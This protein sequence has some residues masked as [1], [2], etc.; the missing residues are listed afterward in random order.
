MSPFILAPSGR[1]SHSICASAS[2]LN[3]FYMSELLL[4]AWTQR[5]LASAIWASFCSVF[6]AV[7][8]QPAGCHTKAQPATRVHTQT[9]R[10]LMVMLSTQVTSLYSTVSAA[11]CRSS[12]ICFFRS[13]ITAKTA[14]MSV[15]SS[16]SSAFSPRSLHNTT[17]GECRY[18]G[19]SY[20]L[21]SEACS[22]YTSFPY[23]AWLCSRSFL[24]M[25]S[26]C[27]CFSLARCAHSSWS[28]RRNDSRVRVSRCFSSTRAL[29]AE[30]R[31]VAI[32][33]H[34]SAGLH[35]HTPVR[36]AQR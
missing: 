6:S 19:S 8:N 18:D 14:I 5:G 22:A 29:P 2:D 1:A 31:E 32:T 30:K 4:H 12:L 24:S 20:A 9:T 27:R 28:L 35:S 16:E 25:S 10:G 34:A 15:Q 7:S 13:P 21:G 17:T 26:S 36:G 33:A 11:F 23:S 3:F